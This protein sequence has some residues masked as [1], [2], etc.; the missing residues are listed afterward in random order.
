MLTFDLCKGGGEYF[1]VPSL[2]HA[3]PCWWVLTMTAVHE[4]HLKGT[5]LVRLQRFDIWGLKRFYQIHV[6][7]SMVRNDS[8][9]PPLSIIYY[10]YN[11]PTIVQYLVIVTKYF[12][13]AVHTKSYN[14][15]YIALHR[16]CMP[17]HRHT[18]FNVDKY[19]LSC[20]LVSRCSTI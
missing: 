11:W 6:I 15:I 5:L 16:H 14:S 3:M 12:R 10:N 18:L 17:R 13:P 7:H 19:T 8:F 4:C 20:S 2:S 1:Q 9:S